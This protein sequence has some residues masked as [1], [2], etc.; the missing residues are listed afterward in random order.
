MVPTNNRNPEN[1]EETVASGSSKVASS[2]VILTESGMMESGSCL[3]YAAAWSKKGNPH[4]QVQVG[5]RIWLTPCPKARLN[6]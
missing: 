1:T 5:S 6:V 4:A 3:K 2:Y